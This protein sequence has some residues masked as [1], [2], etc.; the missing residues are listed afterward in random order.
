MISGLEWYG[1]VAGA[2]AAVGGTGSDVEVPGALAVGVIEPA[3][4]GW[5]ER[6]PFVV[7]IFS[8]LTRRVV[9]EL[10]VALE[11]LLCSFLG[12]LPDEEECIKEE[13]DADDD[14][15]DEEDEEVAL[16]RRSSLSRLAPS[17]C[18]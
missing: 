1:G 8:M 17:G 13:E 2:E 10:L 5:P 15:E 16:E 7:E 6:G 14:E 11:S 4:V 9:E 12:M 18:C 3:D